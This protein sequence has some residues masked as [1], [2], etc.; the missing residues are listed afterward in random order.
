MLH[1]RLRVRIARLLPSIAAAALLASAPASP[2]AAQTLGVVPPAPPGCTE[3]TTVFTQNTPAPIPD[4]G[5]VISTITVSGMGPYL[6]DLNVQTFLT[7]ADNGNVE[8]RLTSPQGTL[9]DFSFQN[10]IG[11]ADVFNGA[12]WDDDAGDTNPPG[13]ASLAVYQSGQLMSPVEPDGSFGAFYG[14]NPNGVWT[15][16]IRDILAGQSGTMNSWKLEVTTLPSAPGVQTDALSN[17]ATVPIPDDGTLAT[18]TIDV[19]AGLPPTCVVTART[20]LQHEAG[21]DIVM[22]LTSPAGTVTSLTDHNGK[23]APN[24][25]DGTLWYDKAPDPAQD[26][27]YAG[28]PVPELQPEETMGNFIGEDP[29]GT[30]TLGIKDVAPTHTGTLFGWELTV[31][32]CTCEAAAAIAPLR[33]DAHGGSGVSGNNGVFEPGETVQVE[34][35]WSNPSQDPF[36]LTGA[37]TNFTG[38]SGPTY[39]IPDGAADFGTLA[40]LASANCFDATG[41]CYALEATGTRPQQHWDTTFDETV[42]PSTTAPSSEKTWT[43]HIGGSFNDVPTSNQFYAFIENIFH[44]GVTGGCNATDYCP[45]NPALRKQMAVFVLKAKEGPAYQPA[46]ATGIFTDVP[47]DNPFA[48]WIEE[49]FHRGVVAGCG[50]GPTYCPDN[51]V[52]RQQMSVFLLK[53]LL[54]SSYVPPAPVGLFADVPISN[55]FAPWIEDLFNRSIAAGCGGGNFCPTNPNTRGQMAP[56][57]AKTFGLVLYGP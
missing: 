9:M 8:L 3:T 45:T 19:P 2:G 40:S 38:P 50:A 7:H 48:P 18:S 31:S 27:E 55:P 16:E 47:P 20:N 39:N 23:V 56:F 54:G 34:T 36:D 14:E 22:T 26:H 52:L 13:P 46:P 10:G 4:P 29:T 35:T 6:W 1:S 57:L 12:I 17:P 53:T 15:L 37:A 33:V 51:A 24:L 42:T 5:T 41:N 32:G 28:V 21:S 43:L 30:W 25:F 44:H 49:L 11:A